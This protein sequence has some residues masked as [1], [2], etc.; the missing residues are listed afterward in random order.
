MSNTFLSKT[1]YIMDIID[2]LVKALNR[3]TSRHK[4]WIMN[5]IRRTIDCPRCGT[6]ALLRV[7]IKSANLPP[8]ETKKLEK[9]IDLLASNKDPYKKKLEMFKLLKK[10]EVGEM[11]PSEGRRIDVL[12]QGKIYNELAKQSLRE[13]K[14][15]TAEDFTKQAKKQRV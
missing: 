4:K 7:N 15:L 14:K 5:K 6:E 13:Y 3:N 8:D 9:I 10:L 12:L 2:E 1:Y 11:E